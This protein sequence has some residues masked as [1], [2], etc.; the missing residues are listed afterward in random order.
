MRLGTAAGVLSASA[1]VG[2]AVWDRGGFGVA[3]GQGAR[4]V[5]DYRLRDRAPEHAE[6]AIARGKSGEL[7][8]A[9]QLVRRAVDAVGGIRRFVSRGD[10]VVV[11]P[12]IGWDRMLIHAANT[13]C[14]LPSTGSGRRG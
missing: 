10:I 3:A 6:L 5:R 14:S 1:L 7:V 4:Q 12:N 8:S 13:R 2:R 11:K 9:E